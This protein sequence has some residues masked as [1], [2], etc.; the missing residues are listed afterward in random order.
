MWSRSKEPLANLRSISHA[1]EIYAIHYRRCSVGVHS[2]PLKMKQKSI[3]RASFC[4]W[5]LVPRPK[6][7]ASRWDGR[8]CAMHLDAA[9]WNELPGIPE[10]RVLPR[11]EAAPGIWIQ[12]DKI[13]T[14]RPAFPRFPA[15]HPSDRVFRPVA[16]TRRAR[17]RESRFRWLI[18]LCHLAG[19]LNG[20]EAGALQGDRP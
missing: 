1:G 8:L 16:R 18:A 12:A 2:R 11:I 15:R 6:C 10:L 5:E 19:P 7:S 17:A 13:A 4:R 20:E 3:F 14:V 9:P